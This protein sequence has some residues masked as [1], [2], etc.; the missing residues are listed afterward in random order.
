MAHPP[1]LRSKISEEELYK[2]YWK[3]NLKI[4]DIASM[5]GVTYSAVWLYMNKL[6]INRR[7]YSETRVL[8]YSVKK[9]N[10]NCFS[11]WSREVAYVLGVIITDG[12]IDSASGNLRISMTDKDVVEKIALAMEL[13]DGVSIVK[14]RNGGKQQYKLAICRQK[15][16]EDLRHL[17]VEIDGSKTFDQKAIK[18]P[19]EFRSHFIRGVFDGDGSLVI[20]NR[21]SPAGTPYKSS[22]VTIVSAS[23]P[24]LDSVLNML[25]ED[26][27]LGLHINGYMGNKSTKIL[28]RINFSC[29]KKIGKFLRYIYKDK[30]NVFMER[31]Y[32]K[33]IIDGA[34]MINNDTLL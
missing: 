15:I 16:T 28:Y 25:N 5:Y 1:I 19:K 21:I 31:K 9:V 7:G 11:N 34:Y 24:F 2:L 13:E 26:L 20:R 17:G 23:K 3:D 33:A 29:R 6:G 8:H 22:D 10:E 27:D 32:N 18:V 30:G 14:A 4:K 12:S